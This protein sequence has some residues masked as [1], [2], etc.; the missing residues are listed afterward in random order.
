MNDRIYDPARD[1]EAA[2]RIWR[3]TGWVVPGKEGSFDLSLGAGRTLV[4]D[5]NG[6]PEC[7]VNTM[8]G[9]LR[10]LREDL[11][12]SAVTAVT[13]SRLARKQGL[14]RRL[15][16]RAVAL[17]AAEGAHIA[18]LGMFE[19]GY[20]NQLGFGTGPYEHIV[21]FDPA[22][23]NVRL[24]PRVPRRITADDWELVHA[25]RLA[26][27]RDHGSITM[28]AEMTRAELLRADNGFGLGYADGPNGELTHYFWCQ[29]QAVERGPYFVS[30]MAYRTREQFLELLALIK[31]LGDQVRLVRM[32]EPPGIQLQDLLLHPFRQ[33]ALTHRSEFEAGIRAVAYWQLRI[34]DLSACLERTHLRTGQARFNLRLGDPIAASLDEE[35][36]WRGIAGDYLVTLGPVSGAEVGRDPRLP[37]LEASV[38]AFTRMW[39]GVR[40][41]TG[42]ACTDDLR[43]PEALLQELDE[44]LRLPPPH[45]GWEI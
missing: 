16:A 20:Y 40:P 29:T 24:R 12:F 13:T 26:R 2:L 11:R 7:L 3:E 25:A 15:T 44:L 17:D 32:F 14:A 19:Q 28:P 22:Q 42:L 23:L 21:A 9:T 36:P 8:P 1:R 35:A 30:N 38:G 5:L 39:M 31:S 27:V 6:A 45:L 41:A 34:L 43:G 4:A 37:T 18:G 10:Y 33:R